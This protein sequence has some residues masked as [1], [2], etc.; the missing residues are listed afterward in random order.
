[1]FLSRLLVL[2]A[3]ALA[4]C[5]DKDDSSSGGDACD[6]GACECTATNCACVGSVDCDITCNTD[7]GNCGVDCNADST[8]AVDCATS[9][10]CAVECS[11]ADSCDVTCAP[12][13]NC[14]VE[15]VHADG[16][17]VDCA[18]ASLCAVTC[19][20]TGCAVHNCDMLSGTCAVTCGGSAP[21]S[22]V[23]TEITCP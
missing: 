11:E 17:E 22:L 5:G 23:G 12:G 8:C 9:A 21:S 14:A 18:G 7:G 20:A 3:L 16:C 4:A 2:F 15:C 13:S 10:D 19:P 1:M 6:G